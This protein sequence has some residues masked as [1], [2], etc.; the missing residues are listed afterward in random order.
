MRASSVTRAQGE[1]GRKS[2]R[3][4]SGRRRMGY[5]TYI[6]SSV[7]VVS[8]QANGMHWERVIV[9]LTERIGVDW[10]DGKSKRPELPR[11]VGDIAHPPG[12]GK[13]A[14]NVQSRI[15]YEGCGATMGWFRRER[16]TQGRD[17][18]RLSPTTHILFYL[19]SIS[20]LTPVLRTARIQIYDDRSSSFKLAK[21]SFTGPN[22]VIRSILYAA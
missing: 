1:I 11:A 19:P 18:I 10:E 17:S 12:F 20:I 15:G 4:R 6:R 14:R 13:A 16:E 7:F 21:Q 22:S 5:C 2:N 3:K 9:K 8:C